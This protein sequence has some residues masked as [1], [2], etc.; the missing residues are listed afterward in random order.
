MYLLFPQQH[1][2]K[3]DSE[4][5]FFPSFHT[6]KW[7]FDCGIPEQALIDWTVS[8]LK[9]E[10]TFIDIGAHIGTY[11]LA[12]KCKVHAF[13]CDP[14][15]FC[16]LAANVALKDK[17]DKIKIHNVALSD[18]IGKAQLIKRSVD[19][20]GNG[21]VPLNSDDEQKKKVEV[22]TATLDYYELSNIKLIKI[23]VEGNELNVIKGALETLKRNNYPPILFESWGAWK[24]AE[25]IPAI[26]LRIDLF[27]FLQSIGYVVSPIAFAPDMFL[28]ENS[29]SCTITSSCNSL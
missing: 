23:D 21:I 7:F 3:I 27:D 16:Y 13:E 25:G 28:A 18:E 5:L 14:T 20:G 15:T 4:L 22:T 1:F 2:S 17:V 11:S 9:E 10:D 12:Q 26:K 8:Q 29:S 24:E 19:G 6:G